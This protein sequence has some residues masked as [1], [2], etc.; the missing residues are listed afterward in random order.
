M[1]SAVAARCAQD[2]VD[3]VFDSSSMYS[4]SISTYDH[5]DQWKLYPEHC[6]PAH[7]VVQLSEQVGGPGR[8]G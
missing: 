1:L 7:A 6:T 2:T 4:V 5:L 3:P 8:G